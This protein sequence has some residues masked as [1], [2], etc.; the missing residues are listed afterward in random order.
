[1]RTGGEDTYKLFE[2]TDATMFEQLYHIYER[3][4][5]PRE[6]KSRAQISAAVTRPEYQTLVVKR[7]GV[8]IG[9]SLLFAPTEE[10]FGLLEY[11]AVHPEF[12][13]A[14]VGGEL[15][16]RT[17]HMARAVRGS[18][19]ILLEVES[20]RQVSPDHAIRR[21]RQQFYS[22]L[23]CRRIDGLSYLLPLPGD[24]PAPQMDLLVCLPANF[25]AIHKPLLVHWLKV[26]YQKVYNCSPNDDRIVRMTEAL[27]DPVIVI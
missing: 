23:G 19:P 15:F 11:M 18:I 4:I 3:S 7:D 2:S 14:G 1:M 16:R 10:L 8:I 6:R 25:S 17:I 13:N 12:R 21:R 20:D 27:A 9:F 5:P 26:V 24:G 22:R